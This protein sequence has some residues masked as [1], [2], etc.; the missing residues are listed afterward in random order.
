MEKN[1]NK[2]D[3]KRTVSDLYSGYTEQEKK[4]QKRFIISLVFVTFAALGFGGWYIAHQLR[5]PFAPQVSENTNTTST[6]A[7]GSTTPLTGIESLREK[8]TDGDGLTDY[9]EFYIYKTSPYIAD[10]DSDGLPDKEEIDAGNDPN[11][12]IGKNCSRTTI[13]NT[14]TT[15]VLV[16][17]V[18]VGEGTTTSNSGD[19][20][21]DELRQILRDAGASE[22][23]LSQ[24][25]DED[26]LATYREIEADRTG[27]EVTNTA[28]DTNGNT[29]AATNTNSSS[30]DTAITYDILQNL[31]A[32]EI[33]Q[34][35]IESG[36]PEDTLSQI[37][38]E[39]LQTIFL[40]SLSQY[41]T[42]QTSQ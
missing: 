18:Q 40:D 12:P 36:V 16:N 4:T 38:D 27:T 31:S 25:S 41:A 39:T 8:D 3:Q 30:S 22:E 32:D 35:L 7:A 17:G 37:D 29:N 34:F 23:Q 21:A 14:N 9:D 42:D 6:V 20:T 1:K 11:C 13:A 33:R 24:I 28:T 10:S 5:S 19:L 2:K 26:L 15:E